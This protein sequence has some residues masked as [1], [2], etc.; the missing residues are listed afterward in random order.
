MTLYREDPNVVN[1]EAVLY[2]RYVHEFDG[3]DDSKSLYWNMSKCTNPETIS[4]RRREL[5]R[6]GH[7]V[8]SKDAHK[9]RTEAFKS[10]VERHGTH[11]TPKIVGQAVYVGLDT[12]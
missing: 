7:I 10:E 6:D 4:R 8:Y 5:H 3:A 2:D 11:P 1:D 12:K 9:K